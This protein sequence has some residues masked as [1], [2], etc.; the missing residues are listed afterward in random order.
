MLS[1]P[2]AVLCPLPTLGC[3]GG[4]LVVSLTTIIRRPIHAL[5]S[6]HTV[7]PLSAGRRCAWP[8]WRRQKGKPHPKASHPS[9]PTLPWPAGLVPVRTHKAQCEFGCDWACMRTATR[10]CSLPAAAASTPLH[11]LELSLSWIQLD[12]LQ[13]LQ[14]SGVQH[15][16]SFLCSCRICRPLRSNTAFLSCAVAGSAGLW[17]P[18]QLFYLHDHMLL[19]LRLWLCAVTSQRSPAAM[20]SGIIPKSMLPVER[21]EPA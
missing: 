7:H 17:G 14:A 2:C 21:F 8:R 3:L 6:L 11:D 10:A 18:T 12:Q 13:D 9:Q 1:L 15:S 19:I 5:C 4:D 20:L 16:F